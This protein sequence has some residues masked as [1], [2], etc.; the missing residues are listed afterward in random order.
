MVIKFKPNAFRWLELI[1][2]EMGIDRKKPLATDILEQLE[3]L[4]PKDISK[5]DLST[6][7]NAW[8]TSDEYLKA[9]VDGSFTHYR[10]NL[11]GT[12]AEAIKPHHRAYARGILDERK[13]QMATRKRKFQNSD[14]R[15]RKVGVSPSKW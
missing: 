10:F 8:T 13:R 3:K 11:D 15:P 12:E 6:A 14:K 1:F 5:D 9:V 7:L 2:E 4:A